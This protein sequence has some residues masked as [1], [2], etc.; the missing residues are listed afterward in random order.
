M[1]LQAIALR[2]SDDDHAYLKAKSHTQNRAM[3]RVLGDDIANATIDDIAKALSLRL[4]SNEP[5]QPA[6]IKTKLLI[7]PNSLQHLNKI[8]STT[9]LS[10]DLLVRL[11]LEANRGGE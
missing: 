10:S 3:G 11:I 4:Q 2:I 9:S 1:T 7:P 6:T 8:V 5:P